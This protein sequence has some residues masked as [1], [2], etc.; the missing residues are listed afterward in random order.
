MIRRR[1]HQESTVGRDSKPSAL[2]F[3]IISARYAAMPGSLSTQRSEEI[4]TTGIEPTPS[5]APIWRNVSDTEYARGPLFAPS[6]GEAQLHR[7][8]N[9]GRKVD[10]LEVMADLDQ[11]DSIGM[12]RY[13]ATVRETLRRI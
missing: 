8:H 13:P 7:G 6:R 12:S 1:N 9:I 11:P 4:T 10:P 5:T 2:Q 3:L